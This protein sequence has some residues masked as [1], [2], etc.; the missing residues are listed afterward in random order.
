MSAGQPRSPAGQC[1]S[2]CG[3]CLSFKHSTSFLR[4]A[5]QGEACLCHA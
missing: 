1:S 4:E 5:S 2:W 3:L